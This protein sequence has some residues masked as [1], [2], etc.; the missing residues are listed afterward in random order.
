MVVVEFEASS[1]VVNETDETVQ[2]CLKKTGE[3]TFDF[4][5]DIRAIEI[6]SSS[7]AEGIE[8]LI[9]SCTWY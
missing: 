7:Q 8:N 9:L 1:Y 3:A 5:V 6:G 4:V 2:A